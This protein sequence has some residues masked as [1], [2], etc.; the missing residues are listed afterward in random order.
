MRLSEPAL[1]VD[2]GGA[3]EALCSVR[4]SP[5]VNTRVSV[6]YVTGGPALCAATR[7]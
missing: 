5:R 6:C 1:A 7:S 2:K 3:L 4:P